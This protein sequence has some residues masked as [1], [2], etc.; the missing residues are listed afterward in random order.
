MFFYWCPIKHHFNDVKF[1]IDGCYKDFLQSGFDFVHRVVLHA[2]PYEG[3]AY[4][5]HNPYLFV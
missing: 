1:W 3:G 4:Y 2:L 5:R